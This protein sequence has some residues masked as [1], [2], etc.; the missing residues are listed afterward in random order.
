MIKD[1]KDS[2]ISQLEN[3]RT[4]LYMHA[5]ECIVPPSVRLAHST[6]LAHRYSHT[7]RETLGPGISAFSNVL[8][9]DNL[10]NELTREFSHLVGCE[11]VGL[12]LLS[13]MNAVH[14]VIQSIIENGDVVYCVAPEHGGHPSVKGIVHS[15][16]G[17]VEWLPFDEDTMEIDWNEVEH[18]VASRSIRLILL[19]ISDSLI[20]DHL[21][22][23]KIDLGECL[24]CV[25]ISHYLSMYFLNDLGNLFDRGADILL[26]STHKSFPG[27]HK[28]FIAIEDKS[29]SEWVFERTKLYVSSDHSHHLLALWVALKEFEYYGKHFVEQSR[30]N[31]QSLGKELRVKGLNP[32]SIKENY[33]QAHQLWLSFDNEKA[34]RQAFLSLEEIGIYTNLKELSFNRG[35]GLRVGVQE[36]TILGYS[37]N[38]MKD[39]AYIISHRT[40]NKI[41]T[42][43]GVDLVVRFMEKSNPIWNENSAYLMLIRELNKDIST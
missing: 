4:G 13:G 43:E 7:Q 3:A 40:K 39:I 8:Y 36:L 29:L 11:N 10:K 26:G 9:F 34:A 42:N 15:C 25:D 16:G 5:S 18:R 24:L 28:G 20:I 23:K 2:L 14:T 19:D 1:V 27:P 12:N 22:K 35:W 21:P 41:S 37:E 30:R 17:K 38:E 33:G 6:Q 32:I 31:L